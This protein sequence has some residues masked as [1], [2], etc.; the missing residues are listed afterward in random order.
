MV[1]LQTLDNSL[2]NIATLRGIKKMDREVVFIFENENITPFIVDF[3]KSDYDEDFINLFVN[4]L[5]KKIAEVLKYGGLIV[6][7]DILAEVVNE[8]K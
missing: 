1:L 6:L 8:R 3:K 4:K 7:H 5:Y 2:I